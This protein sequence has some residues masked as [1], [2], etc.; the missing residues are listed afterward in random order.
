MKN[1]EI[2]LFFQDFI[3][4]N[5]FNYLCL[6]TKN[7]INMVITLLASFTDSLKNKMKKVNNNLGKT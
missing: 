2:R 7:Q 3:N 6:I 1:R 4:T 5:F